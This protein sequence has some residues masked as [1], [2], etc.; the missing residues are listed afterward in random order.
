MPPNG[1][2]TGRH[3]PHLVIWR[4]PKFGFWALSSMGHLQLHVIRS[5]NLPL[6]NPN[7]KGRGNSFWVTAIQTMTIS[8]N[9]ITGTSGDDTVDK[10][11][12]I[13]GVYCG[14]AIGDGLY[15][16]EMT[17]RRFTIRLKIEPTY[18]RRLGEVCGGPQYGGGKAFQATRPNGDHVG[19]RRTFKA[20]SRLLLKFAPRTTTPH[21]LN[22]KGSV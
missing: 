13:G 17:E 9:K 7:P 11:A 3:S 20:A 10:G 18:A 6:T 1:G 22:E 14:K 12:T 8:K 5:S 15:C 19:M 2:A 16:E 4:W 21:S